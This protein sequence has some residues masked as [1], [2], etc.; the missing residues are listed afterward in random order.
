MQFFFIK[1]FIRRLLPQTWRIGV[2]TQGGHWMLLNWIFL[3]CSEAY[4]F[5]DLF[6]KLLLLCVHVNECEGLAFNHFVYQFYLLNLS[7][8]VFF[9]SKFGLSTYCKKKKQFWR[10]M[11]FETIL[12]S[13]TG[14]QNSWGPLPGIHLCARKVT[15]VL[16]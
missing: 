9:P 16:K 12:T 4:K 7:Q 1:H 6:S 8:K 11:P 15:E 10:K 2:F 5:V 3:F 13:E 14:K